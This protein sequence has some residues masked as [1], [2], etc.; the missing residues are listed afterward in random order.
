MGDAN[1]SKAVWPHTVLIS[2]LDPNPPFPPN[3]PQPQPAK[4]PIDPGAKAELIMGGPK[5]TVSWQRLVQTLQTKKENFGKLIRL[6]PWACYNVHD[7]NC[8]LV[9]MILESKIQ[10]DRLWSTFPWVQLCQWQDW[11]NFQSECVLLG[12]EEGR[13]CLFLGLFCLIQLRAGLIQS[14]LRLADKTA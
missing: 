10:Y 6:K 11:K 2:H 5:M 14:L 9:Y 4:L 8:I 3:T 12:F 7:L 1:I 13:M